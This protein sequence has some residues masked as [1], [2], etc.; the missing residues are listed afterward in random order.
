[1]NR[2]ELLIRFANTALRERC[3]SWNGE[4]AAECW[5]IALAMVESA[6]PEVVASLLSPLPALEESRVLALLAERHPYC[7]KPLRIMHP[8]D[9]SELQGDEQCKRCKQF[10]DAGAARL[11]ELT[12]I[13]ANQ[14]V[15][16]KARRGKERLDAARKRRQKRDKDD[17]GEGAGV[18]T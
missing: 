7:E 1:M 2:M 4:A 17:D 5:N 15:A 18:L 6:P 11:K 12:E 3:K 14:A 16:E 10:T 8:D 9:T 13:A